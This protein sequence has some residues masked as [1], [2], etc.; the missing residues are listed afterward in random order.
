LNDV[1]IEEFR[2]MVAQLNSLYN[3]MASISK[4][5]PDKAVSA[6]K[7]KYANMVLE[8]ATK[9]LGESSPDLGF[10]HFDLDDLPTSS[11]VVLIISQFVECAEKIRCENIEKSFDGW[12]WRN[13]SEITHI[14][15]NP[16]K[17]VR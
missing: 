17:G 4:K 14:I 6:F 1:D 9:V 11:D 5:N 3:E 10:T 15:T 12:Y 13:D 16:P 8:Q 2:K 7:V